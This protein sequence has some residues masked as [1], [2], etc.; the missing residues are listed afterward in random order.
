MPKQMS[1]DAFGVNFPQSYWE[2][3][4][5]NISFIEKIGSITFFGYA[6]IQARQNGDKIVGNKSYRITP[7]IFKDYF[8]NLQNESQIITGSYLLAENLK[9]TPIGK[10]GQL[11]S[12]FNNAVDV[13]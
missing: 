6:N 9:D 13:P 7:Q 12:F 11:Y 4:Q 1:F 8:Q 10:D 5:I 3:A 2:L